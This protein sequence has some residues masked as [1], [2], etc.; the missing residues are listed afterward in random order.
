MKHDLS[1]I[2]GLRVKRA[3][4]ASGLTQSQL[5]ER[6]DRTKE[7]VSNIERGVSLPGLDTIQTICD[8]TKVPMVSIVDDTMEDS[9]SI[10]LRARLN[11]IFSQLSSNDQRLLVSLASAMVEHAQSDV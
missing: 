1:H 8:V 2:V 11:A 9:K 10:D 4:E 5:A 6:I 3:R 7:A